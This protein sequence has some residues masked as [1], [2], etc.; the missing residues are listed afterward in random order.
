M[1]FS[2]LVRKKNNSP[3]IMIDPLRVE[4]LVFMTN[5][6]PFC[7]VSRKQ[8][9][10]ANKQKAKHHHPHGFRNKT[11][12]AISTFFSSFFVVFFEVI[13]ASNSLLKVSRTYFFI[14]SRKNACISSI[15][16]RLMSWAKARSSSA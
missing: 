7:L 14:L 8:S 11:Y 4:E 15:N 13:L 12:Y 2:A 3:K 6:N 5:K 16:S 1:V 9:C 10:R